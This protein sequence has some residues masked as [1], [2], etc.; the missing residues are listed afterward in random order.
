MKNRVSG[1]VSKKSLSWQFLLM[2]P[3]PEKPK[4]KPMRIWNTDDSP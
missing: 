2:D 3:D 1:S 4:A